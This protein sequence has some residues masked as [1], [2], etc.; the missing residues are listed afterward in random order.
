MNDKIFTVRVGKAV[1]FLLAFLICVSCAG[2]ESLFSLIATPS[3][4]P[5]A[6]LL[7]TGPAADYGDGMFRLLV[8]ATPAP[9]ASPAPTVY[10][11]KEDM[12]EEGALFSGLGFCDLMGRKADRIT[13]NDDEGLV[14]CVY[15]RVI[16]EDL[17]RYMAFLS[18]R[19]CETEQ[20]E[21]DS[22]EDVSLIVYNIGEGCAFLLEY[23]RDEE[24]L[25]LICAADEEAD[26]NEIVFP[27]ET[28]PEPGAAVCSHCV[29]GHCK[30]CRGRGAVKCGECLG[31]G[32]CRACHG[33]RGTRTIGW[34]G[35]GTSSFIP[36]AE[37]GGNGRCAEC[38]GKGRVDCGECEHG[39]C[40][41]CQGK[42]VISP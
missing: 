33:K 17:Q 42:Y 8:T 39:V 21:T 29:R 41:Y 16:E 5:T 3:P 7:P 24:T 28:A 37:C 22:G 6:T 30:T 23:R 34:G 40:G 25:S 18:D 32:R 10:P 11:A 27:K 26:E 35:V 1:C 36:C 4:V 19:G 38:E 12:P 31:L 14:E 15:E 9:E 13:R 2:A 20:M